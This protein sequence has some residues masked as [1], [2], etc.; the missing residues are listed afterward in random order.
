MWMLI[1]LVAA[2]L[3][4][5]FR[6]AVE[7]DIRL[8]AFAACVLAVA[9][10]VSIVG[11]N[12][13]RP[14]SVG[15][16]YAALFGLF[17]I[18][19]LVPIA[20]GYAPRM[21]NAIDRAWINSPGLA[22]AAFL[23]AIAETAVSLGYLVR[24]RKQPVEPASSRPSIMSG[25]TTD[26]DGPAVV[27]IG[28][29]LAGLAI[30]IGNVV[31]AD[32]SLTTSYADFLA[33]TANMNMPT[34]YLLI[35]FGMGVVS[36]SEWSVARQC[37]LI[38]F[39]VWAV[40][41]FL[42]GLRG[43]VIIPASAFLVVAARRHRIRLRAWMVVAVLGALAAGSAVRVVRRAGVGKGRVAVSDLDPLSGLAELGYSIRP[44][45]VVS[46]YHDRLGQPFVG[47]ATYLAPF[48]RFIV[49][50][51]LGG[52]VL[53][54]ADDP[55]VFGGWILRHV[56]PIG[57]SP[58][59][60]AYRCGGI[61]AMVVVMAAV[62]VVLA[63]LDSLRNSL[64]AN[65]LVGMIAFVLLLWVRNDFTPVPA[66]CMLTIPVVTLIWLFDHLRHRGRPADRAEGLRVS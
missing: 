62:G 43:E 33:A 53:S 17:H 18:G 34:A 1:F 11:T 21:F 50:R 47:F 44:M 24:Y 57:G 48:R 3:L 42:L 13:D 45:V 5:A 25:S 30:W 51:L 2:S 10:L 54:V 28:M 66:E 65:A 36:S 49:G 27:G 39:G 29:L 60:E 61:V 19:L 38:A 20:L 15:S 8:G 58:A 46:D 56:G 16:V 22:S 4:I 59:A 9:S 26:L 41:A 63:S 32:V 7:G 37:A 31:M 40:P 55:S 12:R 6:P 14:I 64:I 35:G 52:H 23:V